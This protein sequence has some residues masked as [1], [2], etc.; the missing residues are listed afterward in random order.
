M[1]QPIKPNAAKAMTFLKPILLLKKAQMGKCTGAAKYVNM[2]PEKNHINCVERGN[3]KKFFKM[4]VP[5]KEKE[6]V[7]LTETTYETKKLKENR[8]RRRRPSKAVM[9]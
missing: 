9:V 7:T 3:M 8:I 6:L 1:G 5:P 4:E 2:K